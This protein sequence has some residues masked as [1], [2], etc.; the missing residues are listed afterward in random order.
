MTSAFIIKELR[1]ALA[2]RLFC[3]RSSFPPPKTEQAEL[4]IWYYRIQKYV[5]LYIEENKDNGIV[6][7]KSNTQCRYFYGVMRI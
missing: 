7:Y 6:Y 2:L 3:G 5:L 4:C 1:G